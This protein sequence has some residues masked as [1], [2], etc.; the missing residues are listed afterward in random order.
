[1]EYSPMEI[2]SPDI[3]HEAFADSRT[4]GGFFVFVTD[5]SVSKRY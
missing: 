5:N 3:H 1:M 2:D 4:C